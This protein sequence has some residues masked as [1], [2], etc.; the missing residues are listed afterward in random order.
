MKKLCGI[1]MILLAMMI[2]AAGAEQ[3][4]LVESEIVYTNYTFTFVDSL[5]APVEGVVVSICG[6]LFCAAA[7]SDADGIAVYEGEPHA[8]EVH[9]LA[10]PEGYGFDLTQSFT[11]EE[12]YGNMDFV[13][14]KE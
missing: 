6:D 14:E 7:V 11:T 12:V 10:L 5:G 8:Y 4:E 1:L 3:V 9:I 13:L 2:A